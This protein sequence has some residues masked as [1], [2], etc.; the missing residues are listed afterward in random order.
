[1]EVMEDIDLL[2]GSSCALN[3]L[4]SINEGGNATAKDLSQPQAGYINGIKYR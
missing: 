1:M 3:R 2:S 4:N